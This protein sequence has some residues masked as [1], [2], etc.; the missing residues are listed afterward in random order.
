MRYTIALVL[1]I[2]V[3]SIAYAENRQKTRELFPVEIDEKFGYIDKT[4]KI[5][6]PPKFD[7]V[8]DFS[9]GLAAFTKGDAESGINRINRDTPHLFGCPS[10][11]FAVFIIPCQESHVS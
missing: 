2:F 6:I 8:T 10:H 4:G 9:E 1:V 5:V 7:H 11:V 3:S